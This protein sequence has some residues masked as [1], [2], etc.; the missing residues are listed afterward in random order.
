MMSYKR[1]GDDVAADDLPTQSC[2][3]L[4]HHSDDATAGGLDIGGAAAGG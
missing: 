1:T 3:R 4:G 2:Q